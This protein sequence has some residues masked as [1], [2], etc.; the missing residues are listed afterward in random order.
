MIKTIDPDVNTQNQQRGH[1]KELQ[2]VGSE[3]Q[4]MIQNFNQLDDSVKKLK[5]PSEDG[6]ETEQVRQ[7]KAL[8]N[9]K[10]KPMNFKNTIQINK[11]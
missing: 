2:N 6:E 5:E 7:V 11:Y 10:D 9:E 1:H 4:F 8:S 3:H